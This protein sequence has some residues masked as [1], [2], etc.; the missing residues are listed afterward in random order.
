M[1]FPNVLNAIDA[2]SP[3][4]LCWP[5]SPLPRKFPSPILTVLPSQQLCPTMPLSK[6]P[7]PFALTMATFTLLISA[8]PA[9]YILASK[10]SELTSTFKKRGNICLSGPG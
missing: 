9:Y 6:V 8:V 3:L 7:L 4:P 1:A 5:L 2:S 10:Y